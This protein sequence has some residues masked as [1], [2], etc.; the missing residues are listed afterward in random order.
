MRNTK[1]YKGGQSV[2]HII[3]ARKHLRRGS[4]P[5]IQVPNY[6]SNDSP[7]PE[8]AFSSISLSPGQKWNAGH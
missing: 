2:E 7:T 6:N 1:K 5:S 4:N 8:T 3:S